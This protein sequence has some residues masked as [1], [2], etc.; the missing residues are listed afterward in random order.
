MKTA[1]SKMTSAQPGSSTAVG[2]ARE[3]G[4]HFVYSAGAS[5]MNVGIGS[6][7]PRD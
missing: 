5:V 4:K 6:R 1:A 2:F 7:R 3:E